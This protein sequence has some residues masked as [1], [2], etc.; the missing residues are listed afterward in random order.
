[1][2]TWGYRTANVG[3]LTRPGVASEGA[4]THIVWGGTTT[5]PPIVDPTFTANGARWPA[6]TDLRYLFPP[7][8]LYPAIDEIGVVADGATSLVVM[9]RFGLPDADTN[10]VD[11][12]TILGRRFVTFDFQ[13]HMTM[14]ADRSLLVGVS[15]DTT[16]WLQV[17]TPAA[18]L[19][20]GTDYTVIMVYNGALATAADRLRVYISDGL[21]LV[22]PAAASG[23]AVTTLSTPTFDGWTLGAL[24]QTDFAS[25]YPLRDVTVSDV[26]FWT[27]P[28]SIVGY[29]IFRAMYA[30]DP[31]TIMGA[32]TERLHVEAATATSEIF[33]GTAIA[34]GTASTADTLSYDGFRRYP[35]AFLNT[36][37]PTGQQALADPQG[38]GGS[39]FYVAAGT[40]DNFESSGI[41]VN[42]GPGTVAPTVTTPLPYQFVLESGTAANQ[43]GAIFSTPAGIVFDPA[44]GY[45][46]HTIC[47]VDVNTFGVRG[48]IAA[49]ASAFGGGF[50]PSQLGNVIG[51][52]H[53]STDPVVNGWYFMTG[54]T[55]VA[56]GAA[57]PRDGREY[58]ALIVVE[59]GATT[60][61]ALLVDRSDPLNPVIADQRTFTLPSP[62]VVLWGEW[63][64][65]PGS[66]VGPVRRN[67]IEIIEGCLTLVSI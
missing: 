17:T 61:Y 26:W 65:S 36:L 28:A 9:T 41:T 64:A 46:L 44:A 45:V 62:T 35:A 54:G 14:M 20:L 63:N 5:L 49:I 10:L 39:P 30:E 50:E 4:S 48:T 66:A 6:A 12:M 15:L 1:M 43:P 29:D 31:T 21:R 53:D 47:S 25:D 13:L 59:A 23:A 51:Y 19:D 33:G 37:Q 7:S 11:N 52:G 32:P 40:I 42:F 16:S 27:N 58:G 55:R 3:V 2:T 24:Y 57:A 18:T 22:E 38:I 34:L 67:S 60:G 56:L 8:N